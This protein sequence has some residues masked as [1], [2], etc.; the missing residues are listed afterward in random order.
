V[1]AAVI[2]LLHAAEAEAAQLIESHRDRV[3]R[4]VARLE[5]EET[6]D[7][8]AIRACLA[9]DEKITQFLPNRRRVERERG[10]DT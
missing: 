2:D 10:T 4:L 3:A 6:L 7:A 1:D 8:A 5:A 9:P